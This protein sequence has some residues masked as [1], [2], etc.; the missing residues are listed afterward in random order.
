MSSTL[1]AKLAAPK[2]SQQSLL[3]IHTGYAY[4]SWTPSDME[5]RAVAGSEIAA[6]RLAQEFAR[7]GFRVVIFVPSDGRSGNYSGVEFRDGAD[8]LRFAEEQVIDILI[9]SRYV[10]LLDGPFRARKRF[11]WLHDICA[12]GTAPGANDVMHSLHGRIDGIVCQT[13]F[14]VEAVMRWHGID[15]EKMHI[16]G[17][18]TDTTRFEVDIDRQPNR[19]IYASAP[20]RGLDTL[21]DLFPLIRR[22]IPD[23]E[24]HIFYGWDLWDHFIARYGAAEHKRSGDRL[25]VRCNQPGVVMHERA[26]QKQIAEEF[27]KS[28]IWFYPTRFVE[29]FCI[30]ALEAQ[31]GG[32]VCVCSDLGALHNTVGDRGILI[33]GDAYS[34]PYRRQALEHVFGVLEDASRKRLLTDKARRWALQQTWEKSGDGWMLLF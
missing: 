23:A 26:G 2:S 31:L 3:V 22:R 13:D 16:I 30:T 33:P 19:F 8:F 14:Q 4:E 32:A 24:L 1:P 29:T 21:I 5:Q 9:V 12:L 7:R 28:D 11:L 25:K 6:V 34:A 10:R 27:L 18:G 17:L 15:R 20:E